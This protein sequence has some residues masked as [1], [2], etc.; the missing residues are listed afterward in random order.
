MYPE[1]SHDLTNGVSQIDLT[2][3]AIGVAD[4]GTSLFNY[5]FATLWGNNVSIGI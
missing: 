4:G 2:G 5:N 3:N 1:I